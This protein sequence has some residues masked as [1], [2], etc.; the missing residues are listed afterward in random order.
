MKQFFWILIFFSLSETALG[1]VSV[2]PHQSR[3]ASL[4]VGSQGLDV[5]GQAKSLLENLERSQ[6]DID[7]CIQI[8]E[9]HIISNPKDSTSISY[10][11]LA[12]LDK[13][14]TS[15]IKD[16]TLLDK[17]IELS[18]KGISIAPNLANSYVNRSLA[19]TYKDMFKEAQADIDKARLINSRYIR[20][21]EALAELEFKK[22]NLENAFRSY[23]NVYAATQEKYL[24]YVYGKKYGK[25]LLD[26][27]DFVRAS[28]VLDQVYQLYQK[29]IETI[30]MLINS[31]LHSKR[32][33]QALELAKNVSRS[34]PQNVEIAATLHKIGVEKALMLMQIGEMKAA[35]LVCEEIISM[36][37]APD[38]NYFIGSTYLM[39]KNEE[40]ANKYFEQAQKL[41]KEL[42]NINSAKAIYLIKLDQYEL[43]IPYFEKAKTE[44]TNRSITI[45]LLNLFGKYYFNK[46]SDI[47]NA[48]KLFQQASDLNSKDGMTYYYLAHINNMF[49]G[50]HI[51]SLGDYATANDL[52][53]LNE[54]KRKISY[55]VAYAHY[56]LAEK[57][58]NR[59]YGEKALELYN[60]H[61]AFYPD[62]KHAASELLT[63]QELEKELSSGLSGKIKKFFR[64]L[65]KKIFKD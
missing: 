51:E 21:N 23:A 60:K 65:N 55:E 25:M 45:G 48:K 63:L 54:F 40:V 9:K 4:T 46:K 12:Y 61:I 59:K 24:K 17:A 33:D 27:G 28:Q 16:I 3:L 47:T 53:T 52:L 31:Y 26:R 37:S 10:L 8:L 57:K 42:K 36:G 15:E 34:M 49:L 41:D 5:L 56:Q 14:R 22:G 38:C 11:A 62:D 39:E 50:L 7:T 30:R 44:E 2:P 18:N 58:W 1:Q 13:F 35:R 20:I 43:A 32:L 64:D 29:D 6:N 19:Y